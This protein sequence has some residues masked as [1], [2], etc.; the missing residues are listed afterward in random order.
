MF[1]RVQYKL[2]TTYY[3]NKVK[4]FEKAREL[5]NNEFLPFSEG[6]FNELKTYKIITECK[7]ED[8]SK[9]MEI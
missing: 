6:T 2:D 9:F 8:C 1:Y 3:V 7:F 4:A 5:L